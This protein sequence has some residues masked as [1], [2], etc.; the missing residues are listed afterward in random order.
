MLGEFDRII[1]NRHEQLNYVCVC[2]C[3]TEG[4]NIVQI[5]KVPF[6][7]FSVI[8]FHVV[9]TIAVCESKRSVKFQKSKCTVNA[10]IFS[11]KKEPIPPEIIHQFHSYFQH[12]PTVG[13]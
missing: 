8:T 12:K 11:Q 1:K 2:V 6:Y 3:L 13:L 5:F 9:F 10:A 4:C 7:A